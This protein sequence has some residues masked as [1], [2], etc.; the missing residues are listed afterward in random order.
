MLVFPCECVQYFLLEIGST[1]AE[2]R[3]K[4]EHVAWSQRNVY[5]V[6]LNIVSFLALHLQKPHR[7]I[8]EVCLVLTYCK[9]LILSFHFE[10]LEGTQTMN[11]LILPDFYFYFIIVEQIYDLWGS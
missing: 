3:A 11:V 9:S 1:H 4:A 6:H 10:F 2:V 8:S 7:C 5:E